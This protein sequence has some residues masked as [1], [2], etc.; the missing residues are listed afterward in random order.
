MSISPVGATPAIKP[1]EAL[2]PKET[3][4]RNDHDGDDKVRAA[5]SRSAP[6]IGQGGLIDKTA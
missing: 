6:L 4:V 3:A 1:N 2:E 5:P